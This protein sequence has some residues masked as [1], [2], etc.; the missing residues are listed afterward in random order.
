MPL[1]AARA[2]VIANERYV[3]LATMLVLTFELLEEELDVKITCSPRHE[4]KH[5]MTHHHVT[6]TTHEAGLPTD[7]PCQLSDD[8]ET[9]QINHV[10]GRVPCQR[11]AAHGAATGA[12]RTRTKAHT[13]S[14]KLPF[15]SGTFR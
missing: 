7:T 11:I 15:F 9:K 10:G 6:S 12:W 5:T 1:L 3:W 13:F 4:A 14:E 8:H 2:V